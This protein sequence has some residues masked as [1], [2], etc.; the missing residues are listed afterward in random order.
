MVEERFTMVFKKGIIM[1]YANLET[2]RLLLKAISEDDLD[3][4]FN[5]FSNEKVTAYL[6]DNEPL[7]TREE[8]KNIL[9]L[10]VSIDPYIQS[11]WIILDKKSHTKIGTCGFHKRNKQE[12]SIDVG[13][14]LNSKYWGQGYMTEA[15]TKLFEYA[16]S[17]LD[18]Q[19]ITAEIAEDNEG[20]IALAKK[21][22][23]VMKESY[24]IHFRETD[25]MHFKFAL[26]KES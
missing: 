13:Y 11:R 5:H 15:L 12:E 10:Y 17:H 22:R 19:V 24:H 4:I 20:S 18:I 3:F 9:K 1:K 2:D 16:W 23:F 21:L 25:Y 7:E 8:A 14:D 26:K 6:Y